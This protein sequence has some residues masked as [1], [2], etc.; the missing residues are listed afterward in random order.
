MSLSDLNRRDFHRLSMAAMGGLIA[1]AAA[2]CQNEQP[3]KSADAG[4]SKDASTAKSEPSKAEPAKTEV[5]AAIPEKHTCRGLNTCKGLGGG[6]TAGKNA[7]AGQGECATVAEHTCG[8]L[9]DCKGMGGCGKNPGENE[10]K[11]KGGCHVPL[12][13]SAWK[14]IRARFEDKMKADKKPF[15]EA[16]P[17]K[18]AA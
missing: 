14:K 15:G 8:D 16:P 12:M 6:T 13:D 5:A 17:A 11:G 2:G 3:A 7:C 18:K 9:N 4:K 1:G 10:C